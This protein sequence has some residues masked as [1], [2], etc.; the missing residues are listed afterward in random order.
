MDFWLLGYYPACSLSGLVN[1]ILSQ[2]MDQ[3]IDSWL[4]FIGLTI[5]MG[6]VK[7]SSNFIWHGTKRMVWETTSYLL[8]NRVFY[9]HKTKMCSPGLTPSS[10]R[11]I[12]V[13]IMKVAKLRSAHID[14]YKII[15]LFCCSRK[16]W[17]SFWAIFKPL[18][19]LLS[20]KPLYHFSWKLPAGLKTAT[21]P[22]QLKVVLHTDVCKYR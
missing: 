4:I 18:D 19:G 8:G 14:L 2:E 7:R 21:G 17:Q 6:G 9:L 12:D 16:L 3:Q 5:F 22:R 13:N 20:S 11:K 15:I 1:L 10:C